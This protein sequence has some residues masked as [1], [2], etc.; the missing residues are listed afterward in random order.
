MH[1]REIASLEEQVSTMMGVLD[2][3]LAFIKGLA[4]A[5]DK[6]LDSHERFPTRKTYNTEQEN[7]DGNSRS[8]RD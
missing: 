5:I 1:D 7:Q 4:E 3:H 6:H 8:H 2:K